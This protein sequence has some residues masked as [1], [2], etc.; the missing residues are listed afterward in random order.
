MSSRILSH[1]AFLAWAIVN[2]AA[3]IWE[4]YAYL[5]RN[6]LKLEQITVWEKM[7]K[8]QAATKLLYTDRDDESILGQITLSNFWIEGWSEYCKVDS[9]YTREFLQGGYVWYFELLNAFLAVVFI[10]ALAFGCTNIIKTILLIGIVN[11]MVYFATLALE[12]V[13]CRL[14]NRVSR[15]WQYPAYYLISGIWLLVPWCLY[16]MI[17]RS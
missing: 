11:C 12:A 16:E 8:G 17:S 6:R 3:G 5:N 15:W 4:V 13:L 1:P 2:L 7:I 9:R 14:D 10:F